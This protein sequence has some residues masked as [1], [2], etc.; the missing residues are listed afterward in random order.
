MTEVLEE[1]V[2][3]IF[4]VEERATQE[5]SMNLLTASCWFLA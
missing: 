2:A 1:H 5:N 4:I 3:S